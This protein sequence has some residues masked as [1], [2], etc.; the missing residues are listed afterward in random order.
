MAEGSFT[1]GE[2]TGILGGCQRGQI[3]CDTHIPLTQSKAAPWSRFAHLEVVPIPSYIGGDGRSCRLPPS[4][5]LFL[6]GER[7][8]E[9]AALNPHC[10]Q[11]NCYDVTTITSRS[12]NFKCDTLEVF[13]FAD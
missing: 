9:Q 5:S 7:K 8:E 6:K 1:I 13:H 4:F 12:K 11:N 3:Y 10:P 2:T